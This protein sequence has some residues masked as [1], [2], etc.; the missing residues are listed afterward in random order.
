[1]SIHHYLGWADALMSL[2]ARP[3]LLHICPFVEFSKASLVEEKP[4]CSLRPAPITRFLSLFP[5]KL[6]SYRAS[7]TFP[8]VLGF[9]KVINAAFEILNLERLVDAHNGHSVCIAIALT[10]FLLVPL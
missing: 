6:K 8:S 1:M 7:R 2:W 3:L 10:I 5:L 4:S 9:V